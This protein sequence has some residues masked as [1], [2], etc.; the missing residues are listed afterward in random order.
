MW[1]NSRNL[2]VYLDRFRKSYKTKLKKEDKFESKAGVVKIT[3][4]L[5]DSL[6]SRMGRTWKD[7]LLN[8]AEGKIAGAP[9]VANR[10]LRFCMYAESE[11]GRIGA[12]FLYVD[13]FKPIRSTSGSWLCFANDE[14]DQWT[15]HMEEPGSLSSMMKN[16]IAVKWSWA[17]LLTRTQT[18]GRITSANYCFSLSSS[19]QHW[20]EHRFK[21][22]RLFRHQGLELGVL[23]RMYECCSIRTG[24]KI[25][26]V[27]STWTLS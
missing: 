4:K 26:K 8:F 23:V 12:G 17:E 7:A 22:Y 3:E 1:W 6:D 18:T 13:H 27:R 14:V 25:Q 24:L 11:C 19:Q 10:L 5:L 9:S 2:D 20:A 16:V 15:D 21:A